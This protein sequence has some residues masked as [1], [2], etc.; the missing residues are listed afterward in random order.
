LG[1]RGKV[2]LLYIPGADNLTQ[3]LNGYKDALKKYPQIEI[4]KI[5]NDQGSQTE[6]QKECRAVL[7]AEPE[8]AGFGCV[9]AAGGQGAAVAVK[10]MG[11]AGKVKIVAMD[12]DAATLQFI[13]EG[14]IDASV[15]QRTYTM[16]YLALQMLYDLRNNRFQFGQD[17]RTNGVNPLPPNVDTGS[18]VI[19]R[20]NLAQFTR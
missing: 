3:R 20:E 1:G 12:R 18:F 2:A 8:L 10:E 11:K 5:G 6:A 4:V 16:P 9:A 14:V 19:T 15:C 7:Q 13:E 17:W